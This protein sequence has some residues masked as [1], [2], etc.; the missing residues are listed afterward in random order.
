MRDP[1]VML[2]LLR[3]MSDDDNG[4]IVMPATMEMSVH[5]QRRRHQLQLLIDAGPCPMDNV[6]DVRWQGSL[7]LATTSSMLSGGVK[8]SEAVLGGP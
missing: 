1:E 6:T 7:M 8:T 5:A 2:S 4:W 3:E